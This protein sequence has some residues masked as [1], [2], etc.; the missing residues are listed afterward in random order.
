MYHLFYRLRSDPFRLTPDPAFSY[1]HP[2]YAKALAYMQYALRQ[3]EGFILVTGLPGTGKTTLVEQFHAE[4]NNTRTLVARVTS[5]QLQ[6]DELLRLIGLSLGVSTDGQDKAT[7]LHR[8]REFL[9]Q[10]ARAGRR[11]LLLID[12]AQDLPAPALEEL[13]LLGNLQFNARSLLQIFLVGQKQLLDMVQRPA[14]Q[15]LVQRLV[16]ACN[17]EPLSLDETRGYIEHRLR[18]AGWSGEPVFDLRSYHM[19]HRFSEG[20]PRQINKVCSRLMLYGSIENKYSLDCFD[21]YKVL[22]DLFEEL[23]GSARQSS[24]EACVD[25]LN[26]AW[27]GGAAADTAAGPGGDAVLPALTPWP[28]PAA[29]PEP[30]PESADAVV[31]PTEELSVT[32]ETAAR[33]AP[34]APPPGLSAAG[35]AAQTVPAGV[36]A[37]A[38]PVVPA[39]ARIGAAAPDPGPQA[40]VPPGH[41]TGEAKPSECQPSG[42]LL[43]L[44]PGWSENAR[45]HRAAAPLGLA[46]ALLVALLLVSGDRDSDDAAELAGQGEP[47]ELPGSM[48]YTTRAAESDTAA[49]DSRSTAAEAVAGDVAGQDTA[50]GS[51]AEVPPPDTA[52]PVGL[53]ADTASAAPPPAGDR[54]APPG[55]AQPASSQQPGQTTEAS[56]IVAEEEPEQPAGCSGSEV[57]AAVDANRQPAPDCDPIAAVADG[58]AVLPALP[59]TPTPAASQDGTELG[60]ETSTAVALAAAQPPGFGLQ[61]GSEAEQTGRPVQAAVGDP[62]V[63]DERLRI[64]DLMAQAERALRNNRLTTPRGD[65]AY[66]YYREVLELEPGHGAARD[67]M[68][69]IVDRYAALIKAALAQD[70]TGRASAYVARGL[71]VKPDSERLRALQQEVAARE[72][73]LQAQAAR[74]AAQ[75]QALQE[76]PAAPPEPE[77]PLGLLDRLK[78]IFS[79]PVPR[80]MP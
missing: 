78:A 5:T 38:E 31:A 18:C 69:R 80:D 39:P 55:S 79:N 42:R 23:P 35:V 52:P 70:Q 75:A 71:T 58:S 40:S 6:A 44:T 57:L 12:E 27:R 72:S 77:R 59:A 63:D 11:T 65:N 45:L 66:R 2:R 28:P 8:L 30:T 64:E 68:Q 73:W 41:V 7:V 49:P 19:I 1:R 10:Q 53:M 16:A 32:P 50:G 29:V 14:M 3:G 26:D 36:T 21:C 46:A 25:M 4:L 76:P 48:L 22:R 33:A 17:L 15:P 24:L 60:S 13:R 51:L 34:D 37:V 74:E 56:A 54:G 61:A 62:Q 9:I 47:H 67:G 20:F 43:W